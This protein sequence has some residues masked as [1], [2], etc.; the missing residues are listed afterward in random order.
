MNSISIFQNNDRIRTSVIISE[1]FEE[2]FVFSIEFESS[3]FFENSS[4]FLSDS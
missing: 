4:E 1:I 2:I 3:I